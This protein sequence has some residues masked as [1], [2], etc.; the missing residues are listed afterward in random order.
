MLTKHGSKSLEGNNCRINEDGGNNGRGHCC[1]CM[2]D[3]IWKHMHG[4]ARADNSALLM[5]SYLQ[6][7]GNIKGSLFF[8]CLSK[9]FV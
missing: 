4:E 1:K 6:F 8:V 2:H 9:M 3:H 5:L 7:K